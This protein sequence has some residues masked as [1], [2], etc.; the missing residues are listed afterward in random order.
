[1]REVSRNVSVCAQVAFDQFDSIQIAVNSCL[2]DST[3]IIKNKDELKS[4]KSPSVRHL[5][6]SL[7]LR[8]SF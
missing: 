6:K 8:N 7:Y 2:S 3:S 1:M 5:G 4:I